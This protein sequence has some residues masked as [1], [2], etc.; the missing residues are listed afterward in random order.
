MLGLQGHGNVHHGPLPCER[1]RF[2]KPCEVDASGCY[3]AHGIARLNGA[4]MVKG[5]QSLG[6]V[7]GHANTPR[8]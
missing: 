4:L 6:L 8:Q 7:K 3:L 5:F 2:L 1:T